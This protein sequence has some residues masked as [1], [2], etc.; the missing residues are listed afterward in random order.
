MLIAMLKQKKE[1]K[2]KHLEDA[3]AI[4]NAD[5]I[6]IEDKNE[7]GGLG[8]KT[9]QA[10]ENGKKTTF[11]NSP[12]F[13]RAKY[14]AELSDWPLEKRN[15]YY[16]AAI[17]WSDDHQTKKDQS[18]NWA[19]RLRGWDRMHPWN[20][21]KNGSATNGNHYPKTESQRI[22][23]TV[24]HGAFLQGNDAVWCTIPGTFFSG[25]LTLNKEGNIEYW[26]AGKTVLTIYVKNGYKSNRVYK[27]KDG[28]TIQK[29]HEYLLK[30]SQIKVA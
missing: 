22:V 26:N 25:N 16:E 17:T 1:A 15:Y 8:E 6:A 11:R 27:L 28:N 21:N 5:A 4:E 18:V 3:S 14:D 29:V 12:L 2:R 19:R 20:G 24:N 13:D 9:N 7:K 30:E 10:E 23:N